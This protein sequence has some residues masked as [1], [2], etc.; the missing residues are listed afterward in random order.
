MCECL[1]LF[2]VLFSLM[3]F[4]LL[5]EPDDLKVP[6]WYVVWILNS[7]MA[8]CILSWLLLFSKGKKE[9][10]SIGKKWDTLPEVHI[11]IL[12]WFSKEHQRLLL[13]VQIFSEPNNIIVWTYGT[14]QLVVLMQF[15]RIVGHKSFLHHGS[16]LCQD[17]LGLDD[18]AKKSCD[19]LVDLTWD[20]KL[21]EGYLWFECWLSLTIWSVVVTVHACPCVC[22]RVCVC[23]RGGFFCA[24]SSN[25]SSEGTLI[26]L[27]FSALLL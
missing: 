16:V 10:Y 6:G 21:S 25:I 4:P 22:A 8:R 3:N 19:T 12:V 20:V 13:L 5:K 23:G 18:M 1:G 9:I 11:T 7:R 14:A 26:F 24:V 15:S 2:R 17:N 27:L